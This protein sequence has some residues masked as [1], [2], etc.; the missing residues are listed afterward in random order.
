LPA[1][2]ERSGG[3]QFR[4]KKF[5]AKFKISYHI[6]LPIELTALLGAKKDDKAVLACFKIKIP[7]KRDFKKACPFY[8]LLTD[9]H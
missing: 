7:C 6:E 2:P 9:R 3:G 5:R 1:K 8:Y 4:S